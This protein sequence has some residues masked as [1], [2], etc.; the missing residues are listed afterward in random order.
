MQMKKQLNS[1]KTRRGEIWSTVTADNRTAA[2]GRWP[3]VS[4]AASL[5]ALAGKN[6][7]PTRLILTN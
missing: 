1:E 3:L 5:A 6:P 4:S 7:G 2:R